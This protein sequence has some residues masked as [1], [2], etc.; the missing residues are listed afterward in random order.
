MNISQ[1]NTDL[2]RFKKIDFDNILDKMVKL[3]NKNPHN[4]SVCQYVIKNNSVRDYFSN[5]YQIKF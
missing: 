5:I 2:N 1:I 3:F 4:M